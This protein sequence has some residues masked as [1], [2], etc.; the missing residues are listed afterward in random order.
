[1]R[2]SW[3][4]AMSPTGRRPCLTPSCTSRPAERSRSRSRWRY[5]GQVPGRTRG[6]SSL[7]GPGRA[8][9]A[10]GHRAAAGGHGDP[11]ADEAGQLRP[12]VP[13]PGPAPRRRRGE[14]DRRAA[15]QARTAERRDRVPR[16]GDPGA[17]Q[18]PVGLPVHPRPDDPAR[19]QA[20][21]RPCREGHRRH[22]GHPPRHPVIDRDPSPK[23][24]RS[25]EPGSEPASG[26]SR[27]S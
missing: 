16:P 11:R 2:R 6:C 22:R 19:G 24:C 12:A 10:P 25:S 3:C 4:F 13:V 5:P 26:W 18:G 8:G 20:R 1:M 7:P 23:P 21:R 17:A 14:P 27:R 15:V 9:P